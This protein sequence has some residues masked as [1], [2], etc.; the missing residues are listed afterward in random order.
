MEPVKRT[1]RECGGMADA[2]DLESGVE[3][4]GGSSP[5]TR[6]HN[7]RRIQMPKTSFYEQLTGLATPTETPICLQCARDRG[8]D[9]KW[10][11]GPLAG[12]L[13]SSEECCSCKFHTHGRV[14]TEHI[15]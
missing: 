11:N 13:F 1:K 4:R 5:S 9:G 14:G 15:E 10:S 8:I 12:G 3:R 2:P 6:T 7:K